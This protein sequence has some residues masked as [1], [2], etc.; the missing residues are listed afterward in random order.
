MAD[1]I[2]PIREFAPKASVFRDVMSPMVLGMLPDRW[3]A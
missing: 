3:F 1:G 2:V